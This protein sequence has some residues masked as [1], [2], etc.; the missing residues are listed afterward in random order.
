MQDPSTGHSKGY[1]FVKFSNSREADLA[2]DAMQG[3]YIGSKPIR[4]SKATKNK[5][6]PVHFFTY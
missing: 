2:A 3:V 6:T 4:V 5:T 1:G